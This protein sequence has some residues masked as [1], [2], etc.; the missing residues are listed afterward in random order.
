ML[1]NYTSVVLAATWRVGE[2][3]EYGIRAPISFG[4][5]VGVDVRT[6][7]KSPPLHGQLDRGGPGA[8]VGSYRH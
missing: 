6:K 1:M 3:L 5:K 2:V 4:K 8:H 7:D